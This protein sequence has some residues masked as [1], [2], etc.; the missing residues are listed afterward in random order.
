MSELMRAVVLGA[1][2]ALTEFLPVS[3]SGHLVLAS[4]VM[5]NSVESLTFDVGL[6]VGTAAAVLVYFWRDWLRIA[7][8]SLRA[9]TSHGVH[10][11]SW[12]E[13]ARL[14]LWIVVATFPAAVVGSVFGDAIERELREPLVVGAML[15]T[16]A[17][18]IAAA[19]RWGGTYVRLS[20]LT[21]GRALVLGMSQALA[22]LPGVSRS[23]ITIAAA[24][25]MGFDRYSATRFSFL[26]SAPIVAGAGIFRFGEAFSSRAEIEWSALLLG[27]LVS[28][29][30]GAVVIR[31]LL[32]FVR[33]HSFLPFVIYRIALGTLV[34]VLVTR[35][36]L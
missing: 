17:L 9:V 14:G 29:A 4:E 35:G 8:C 2:Q 6:H 24:R 7:E 27:A 5:G 26:L 28:F 31:S 23:G 34:I 1:L 10:V 18:V 22:L 32:A 20:E 33:V 15:I 16:G 19:D 21:V 30:L 13:H 36:S 12:D 11:S 25:S 3:S